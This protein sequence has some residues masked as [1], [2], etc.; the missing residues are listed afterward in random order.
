MRFAW[1]CRGFLFL[2][3][4]QDKKAVLLYCD[5]IHTIEKM[6]NE[7]AGLFFKHYLRYVNDLDPK[8]DNLIVD[9]TFE[10]VKQNLKRDLKK[11][12]QRAERSRENG[13]KGG[14]PPKPVETQKT[15][16]VILEPKKPVTDT[17]TVKVTDTVKVNDIN[18]RE[19]NFKNE[20]LL[21][22]NSYSLKIL[23]AF[24]LYWSEPDKSR[25]KMRFEKEKTWDTS[26]R[27]S[28]WAKNDFS[29]SEN[30]NSLKSSVLES[31]E[32]LK[33]EML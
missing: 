16:R 3:M 4:A 31:V 33:K 20:I 14:R 12:E 8:T 26:R 18:D 29:K 2:D 19:A 15:Q 30:E 7:T 6:D 9:L 21:Y 23:E 1:N 32:K 13:A 24:F 11:W 28:R 17:V 25:K 10:S 27:L 5:L 22:Q